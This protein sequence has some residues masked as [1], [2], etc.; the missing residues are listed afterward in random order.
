MNIARRAI[1]VPRNEGILAFAEK[2]VNH[3]WRKLMLLVLTYAIGK[4]KMFNTKHY[5][6]D[7]RVD[8]S[9]N[10]LAW[11]LKPFQVRDEILELLKILNEIKPEVILEIGTANGGTLFLF[12]HIAS[13]DALII[14]VDLP[15]GMF[16]GG[17]SAWKIPLYKSFALPGQKIHLIR[18]DSHTQS[19]LEKVKSILNG[20]K[21]DFL[22]ID[23]DHTYNGV[24]KDFKMYEPLVKNNGLIAFH[25]IVPGPRE[26]VGGVPE[27][28][29]EIR[30]WNETWEIVKDW[31]QGGCGIGLIDKNLLMPM[32]R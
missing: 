9:L 2:G 5:S 25:D 31:N 14:S 11:L 28:W 23:G 16:G 4:I 17:Y 7:T 6:L 10:S 32:L 20:R 26:N 13:K 1:I 24:K 8:F 21:V 30:E 18:A 12:S 27:F 15:G 19:T 22:F 29:Q 3:V